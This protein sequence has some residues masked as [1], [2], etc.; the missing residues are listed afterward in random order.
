MSFPRK[1]ESRAVALEGQL[2]P[3]PS[4]R[5]NDKRVSLIV[6]DLSI[7]ELV[8]R[9]HRQRPGRRQYLCAARGRAGADFRRRQPDQFRPWLGLYFRRLYRLGGGYVSAYAVA[10]DDADR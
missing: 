2:S 4:L 1:R 8:H 3:D 6:G 9:L 5:G 7:L 10:R